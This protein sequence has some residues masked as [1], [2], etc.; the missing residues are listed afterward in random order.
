MQK[1]LFIRRV[2]YSVC[3]KRRSATSQSFTA[4][5]R[6]ICMVSGERRYQST[7]LLGNNRRQ[8]APQLQIMQPP[9]SSSSALYSSKSTDA[10]QSQKQSN[11]SSEDKDEEEWSAYEKLVRKLYMT[12]LFNPVKLGL[13]NMNK[14]HELLG[15]PM[16]Q[17]NKVTVIHIAGSNGKGSV[18][19]KTSN[20]LSQSGKYKVGLFVSPHISSFRE[21]IQINGTPMRT[22]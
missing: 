16:N 5:R 10:P 2:G 8:H 19:L 4:S 6:S 20:A 7:I 9:T 22:R 13:E 21:R 14:L 12:N 15:N 1:S 18:A 3:G 11:T 17:S